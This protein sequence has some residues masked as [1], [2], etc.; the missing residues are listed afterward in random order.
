MAQQEFKK[1]DIPPAPRFC[2]YASTDELKLIEE[3]SKNENP[4]DSL[5]LMQSYSSNTPH[6]L[7]RTPRD[8]VPRFPV[9]FDPAQFYPDDSDSMIQYTNYVNIMT[10]GQVSLLW[11]LCG[12][13]LG[14]KCM[15]IL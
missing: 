5:G 13:V 6:A 2:R 4:L 8:I 14:N 7:K 12:T 15:Y 9:V 10:K 3:K 1:E 11:V